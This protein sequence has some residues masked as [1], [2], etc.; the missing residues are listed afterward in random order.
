MSG[1]APRTVIKKPPTPKT[2]AASKPTTGVAAPAASILDA[3]GHVQEAAMRK[4]V[5]LLEEFF[6]TGELAETME[7]IQN[8][9]PSKGIYAANYYL[10]MYRVCSV[11]VSCFEAQH[12]SEGETAWSSC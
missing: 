10:I 3:D 4:V 8:L 9:V 11:P 6:I 7:A 2:P 12:G 1:A 5:S